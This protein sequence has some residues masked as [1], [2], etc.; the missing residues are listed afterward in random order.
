MDEVE[1]KESSNIILIVL[2]ACEITYFTPRR[3]K[4][5]G[6]LKTRRQVI[7]MLQKCHNFQS[8]RATSDFPR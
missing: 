2:Y 1:I 8:V 6:Y 7:N 4:D 5:E 3:T